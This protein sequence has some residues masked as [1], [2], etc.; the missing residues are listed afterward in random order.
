MSSLTRNQATFAAFGYI[1]VNYKHSIPEALIKI[2]ALYFDEC[3]RTIW[4]GKS[5]NNIYLRNAVLILPEI[6]ISITIA[7]NGMKHV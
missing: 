2:I 7:P 4:R 6:S 5:L 1:R 3:I